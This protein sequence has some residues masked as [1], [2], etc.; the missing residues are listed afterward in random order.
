MKQVKCGSN[1]GQFAWTGVAQIDD[2]LIDALLSAGVLQ[3]AQRSPSTAAEKEIVGYEKR[4]EKFNRNTI[5]FSADAADVLKKHLS[6]FKVEV[7]RDEKNAPIYASIAMEVEVTEK[8]DSSTDVVMKD[9]RAAYARRKGDTD[10]L[11]ELAEKVGYEGEEMG[12]GTA[13]NAPVEFLR[14]IRAWSKAQTKAL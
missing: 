3:F 7:G 10:A 5:P 8:P 1:F 2:K 9:E 12:D 4:P 14:A 11:V 13:E 6:S